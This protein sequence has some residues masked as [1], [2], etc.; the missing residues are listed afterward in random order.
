[1]NEHKWLRCAGP[2]PKLDFMNGRVSERKIR[3]FAVACCRTPSGRRSEIADG[4]LP[5]GAL[6]G[7]TSAVKKLLAN[8]LGMKSPGEVMVD[9]R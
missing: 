1:M 4:T 7:A 9:C 2:T 3:Q 6:T 5:P 8:Y